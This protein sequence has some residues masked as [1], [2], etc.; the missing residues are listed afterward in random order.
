MKKAIVLLLIFSISLAG[1][2]SKTTDYKTDNKTADNKTIAKNLS[3]DANRANTSDTV[4]NVTKISSGIGTGSLQ[5]SSGATV[6]ESD[7][8]KSGTKITVNLLSGKKEFTVIG[9]TNYMGREVCQAEMTY[10]NGKSTKYFSQ[11]GKFEAMT[12]T[13]SGSGNVYAEAKSETNVNN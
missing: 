1:C 4:N 5:V 9:L 12:S 6:K 2:V 8:C 13:A 11:D 10:E 7:W 3:T